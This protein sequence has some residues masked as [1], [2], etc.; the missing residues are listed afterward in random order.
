MTESAQQNVRLRYFAAVAE[1]AGTAEESV[2]LPTESTAQ[3][4]REQ[5]STAH[6]EEFAR[7]LGVSALLVD[8]ARVEN[9]DV[10]P[11]TEGIQVDVLPPFAGG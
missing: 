10:L 6:S 11:Q 3:V 2:A 8:G 5:L 1:A 7:I 9:E 4:L